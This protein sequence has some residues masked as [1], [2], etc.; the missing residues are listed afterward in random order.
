MIRIPLDGD[1]TP[2]E[3][4]EVAKRVK[5]VHG[6]AAEVVPHSG[7][8]AVKRAEPVAIALAVVGAAAAIVCAC[9]SVWEARRRVKDKH[10]ST[11]AR[12]IAT[13]ETRMAEQ[14][15]VGV[16]VDDIENFEALTNEC[17]EP[18][19]AWLSA[20]QQC[21]LYRIYVFSNGDAGA[22]RVKSTQA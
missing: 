2:G 22:V 10:S 9:V 21:R 4:I 16:I 12:F 5:R 17:E 7:L 13:V 15:V 11:L 1:L 14:G 6:E 19:V 20:E 3:A 8:P 18:C